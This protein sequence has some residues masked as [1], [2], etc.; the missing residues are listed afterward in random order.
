[1]GR[2]HKKKGLE[3]L[4]RAWARLAS[5]FTDWVLVVA[6]PDRGFETTVRRLIQE[7][8]LVQS[9]ILTGNLQGESKREALGAAEVFVLPS[10][11]EGFSMAVLEAMACSL[12]VLLTPECNFP[13]AA[14]SGAAVE[15]EATVRGT[16]AGLRRLLSL[17]DTERQKMGRSARTLIAA[18]YTWDRVAEQT[19]Q[20][21]CWLTGRGLRPEF[22]LDT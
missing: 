1:M 22:V 6:G 17:G 11:S 16:E 20:L 19:M 10:F 7:L 8:G 2:L 13:E 15:V 5:Q 3:L 18:R 4:L 14:A 21:Y 12:P 9:V